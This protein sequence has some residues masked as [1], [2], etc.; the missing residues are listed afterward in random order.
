M[1]KDDICFM[2]AYKMLDKIKTQELSSEEITECIIERIERINPIINA[3]CTPTF[4]WARETAKKADESVKKGEKLGLLHGIP[5]SIKDE[6]PI[7]GIRTTFG[8]KLYENYIPKE[9]DICVSRLKD[10][11]SVILG[12]TNMPEFGFLAITHNLIFG[13]SKNPWNVEKT[14]GGSTGGGAAAVVSGLGPLALGADGGGSIRIPSCLC[15]AY[16]IKPSL[17]RVPVHPT[18]GMHFESLIHYGPIVR[19]VKDA[20][21]MLDAIKGP[22]FADPFTLPE[23]SINYF[24]KIEEKP[25]RLKIGYSVDLGFAK[26]IDAEVK[27]SFMNSV[28]KFEQ[29]GWTVEQAKIKIKNPERAFLTIYSIT[30]AYD[31]KSKLKEWRDKLTPELVLAVEAGADT[32]GLDFVRALHRRRDLFEKFYQYFK[33]YDILLTPTT[34]FPAFELGIPYPDKIDGK[35]VSPTAW[36]PLTSVFNLTGLP[37]ASIPCSWTSHGLP[38]GLQIIGNRFEDLTVLQVSKAFEDIAPWQDKKPIFN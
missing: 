8:S 29:F 24:E 34:A 25:K 31:L 13:V 26:V 32:N 37:A 5:T 7:N 16:G 3:Y 21:L 28:H 36:M 6:M 35:M 11:G 15:G 4:D 18:S 10:A 20:A 33:N 17:G 14:P 30:N 38:I 23:Q 1:N 27:E 19:Y 2:A 22:H 9:D 12:K